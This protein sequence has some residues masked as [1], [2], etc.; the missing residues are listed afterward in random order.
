[1]FAL[2][3]HTTGPAVTDVHWDFLIELAGQERLR[4]W[5]LADSPLQAAP[6]Q[7]I[8]ATRLPDHRPVY[9]TYEGPISGDRGHVRR[10]DHGPAEVLTDSEDTF[11]A[12]LH[13]TQLRGVAT[14]SGGAGELAFT[15]TPAP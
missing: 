7:R 12:R 5:R 3:E 9:L 11:V 6:G 4:T 2:L 14:I 15:L 1:M 10:L 13:G 8:P